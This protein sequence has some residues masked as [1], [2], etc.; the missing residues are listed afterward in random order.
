MRTV[1][2]SIAA[3]QVMQDMERVRSEPTDEA[4]E[5]H[6]TGVLQQNEE[7]LL[8]VRRAFAHRRGQV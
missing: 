3:P 1:R 4:A 8:L 2:E 5:H 7:M 6:L